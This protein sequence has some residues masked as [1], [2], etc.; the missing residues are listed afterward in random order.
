MEVFNILSKDCPYK[1]KEIF[2]E[3][4]LEIST[5]ERRLSLEKNYTL[6][7]LKLDLMIT[8]D[9]LLDKENL[10]CFGGLQKITDEIA[11]VSSRHYVSPKYVKGFNRG[12]NRFRPN[13]QYIVPKQIKTAE[14]LNY[15][16][17]FWSA[18]IYK[19]EYLFNLTCKNAKPYISPYEWVPLDGEYSIYNTSQRVCQI[20]LPKYKE[21]RFEF[22]KP[23]K[24]LFDS[25]INSFQN[26]IM[27]IFNNS[28][29][30]KAGEK[31]KDYFF[32]EDFGITETMNLLDKSPNHPILE[33]L[34]RV[35]FETIEKITIMKI[36]KD[37]PSH[38]DGSI[39]EPRNERMHMKILIEG[40]WSGFKIYDKNKLTNFSADNK[41]NI[42][43]LDNQLCR[44]RVDFKEQFTALLP[45]G[46]LKDEWCN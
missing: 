45:V 38:N 31:Y 46:K 19:S 23:H 7:N 21:F 39:H 18:H 27:K 28:P 33:Y 17:L 41:N 20:I 5:S 24:Q 6:K 35:Y 8:F 29:K 3:E 15:K 37:V 42:V 22:S 2:Y 34:K 4:L 44:H 13:W 10:V 16:G 25:N 11:R 32:H 30:D 12:K 1:V 43:I 9:V 36:Y 40:N 26:D 14:D